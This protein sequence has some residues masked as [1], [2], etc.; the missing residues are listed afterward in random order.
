MRKVRIANS[1]IQTYG[2]R[3]TLRIV[4]QNLLLF[5]RYYRLE[6]DLQM[7]EDRVEPGIPV[8][9][10]P[11]VSSLGLE[12]KVK[13]RIRALRGDYGLNQFKERFEWGDM[14]F[15][16]YL[17]NELVGFVW[18]G[19]PPVTNAGY[20]LQNDEALTYDAWTFEPYRGQRVFPTIK[21][22]IS[23]YLI[24]KRPDIRYIVSH[25]HTKN[26]PSIAG[27]Q[28]AGYTIASR[29]LTVICLGYARR[30]R[31]RRK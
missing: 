17:E 15:I 14:L 29:E 3:K 26:K 7:P 28:R 12:E 10:V 18:L 4:A 13:E 27:N 23:D 22:A 20:A 25:V 6:K 2:F 8:N 24:E 16:A 11:I 31:G 30:F 19:L 9:I 1:L 5:K 21:Q